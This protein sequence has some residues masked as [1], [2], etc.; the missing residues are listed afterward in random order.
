MANTQRNGGVVHKTSQPQPSA[1]MEVPANDSP[2]ISKVLVLG[3]RRSGKS[4][5]LHV[6]FKN[7][8]P[9]RTT[10]DIEP[11]T[12]IQKIRIASAIPLEFWDCPGNTGIQN[13]PLSQFSTVIFVID[14]QDSFSYSIPRLIEVASAAYRENPD[15]N[16]EV[17][18]HKSDVLS[19]D[20]RL[21]TYAHV[22]TRVLDDLQ[23]ESLDIEAQLRF[24]L[25]SIYDHTIRECFSQ[26]IQ[27]LLE[28]LPYLEDL[29]NVFCANS[30]LS[31]AFLFD[32]NSRIYVA[33]DASPVDRA[34]HDLCCDYV[35]MLSQF[36]PLYRDSGKQI[37]S[38]GN[39][40]RSSNSSVRL[41]PD[42]TLSYWQI[43]SNLAI[44]AL[45]P[46]ETYMARRGL[47][48]YN[49]V[50]FKQ[51]VQEILEVDAAERS[52]QPPKPPIAS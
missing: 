30:R 52:R 28:P 33:T 22:Q 9:K 2:R 38:E 8:A 21:D 1:P 17:L 18:V 20:Y 4:S 36:T 25:T 51:G 3:L 24:H 45:L 43:T 19:D 41:N 34:T 35:K 14:I 44:V 42:T 27:R 26:I 7:Y 48:E 6:V 46:T 16:I 5:M 13:L 39:D 47:I 15:I 12:R 40:P 32:V 11:T 23:E 29:L 37:L 10:V 50:F 49:L 31:K